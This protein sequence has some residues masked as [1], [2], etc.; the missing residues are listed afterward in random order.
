[1][2]GQTS[3]EGKEQGQQCSLSLD[4]LGQEDIGSQQELRNED[5]QNKFVAGI[6]RKGL[7]QDGW[8]LVVTGE[9]TL[10]HKAQ[11]LSSGTDTRT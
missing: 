7:Y 8:K 4:Q 5:E 11:C 3:I 10:P 1:M 9:L 6:I 2:Q